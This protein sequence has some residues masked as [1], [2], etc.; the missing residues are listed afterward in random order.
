MCALT[1][2]ATIAG[3]AVSYNLL[4]VLSV[5]SDHMW[6]YK[7]AAGSQPE[8]LLDTVLYEGCCKEPLCPLHHFGKLVIFKCFGPDSMVMMDSTFIH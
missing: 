2:S 4:C 6:Y 8:V 7:V 3:N 5:T 1:L